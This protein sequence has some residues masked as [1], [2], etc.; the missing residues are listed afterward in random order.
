MD[1][2]AMERRL[3]VVAIMVGSLLAFE[4]VAAFFSHSVALLSDVAHV[5]TDFLSA[6]LTLF[7]E[8]IAR[9]PSTQLMS[10]GFK[11]G[12]VVAA[13]VNGFSLILLSVI[14]LGQTILRFFYPEP[15]QPFWMIGAALVAL[16]VDG[17]I[18]WMLTKGEQ[19]LNIKS[20]F[21]HFLGDALVS[22]GVILAAILVSVTHKPWFDPAITFVL[23]SVMIY[24]SWK[25]VKE[26]LL[27]L[28]EGTP[29]TIKLE[30]L[31]DAICRL[32][33][34]LAVHDIHVWAV[35]DREYAASLHV[36]IGPKVV[37][38]ETDRLIKE[39]E[40]ILKERFGIVH[41]AIQLESHIDP[42]HHGFPHQK[43]RE[44]YD[45]AVNHKVVPTAFH[46]FF[47]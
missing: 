42:E 16:S 34:I 4:I 33:G 41:T 20:S 29:N 36:V 10:Y 14:I 18:L 19:N 24:T 35:S 44:I 26:S 11:R 37:I 40:G 8:R 45:E 3:S 31:Y 25:I 6:L 27:I 7:A 47:V 9:R 2:V 15:V 32:P 1:F 22:F 46:T 12:T 28:M 5:G 30:I 38:S 13:F 43:D 39:I 23:V 21:I 17:I